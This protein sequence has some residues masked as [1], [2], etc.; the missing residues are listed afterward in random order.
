MGSEAARYGPWTSLGPVLVSLND[1]G[2]V[3][4]VS[5]DPTTVALAL[6]ALP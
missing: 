5:A 4:S 2:T 3:T 6:E 1:D